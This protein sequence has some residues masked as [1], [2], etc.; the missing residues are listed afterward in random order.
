MLSACQLIRL[1]D[2]LE[3][4]WIY[5]SRINAQSSCL[6]HPGAE[7][8]KNPKI[9]TR[10]GKIVSKL[11]VKFAHHLPIDPQTRSPQPRPVFY[12]Q[13]QILIL[14]LELH[15]SPQIRLIKD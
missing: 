12:W 15:A 13:V 2:R 11:N 8:E 14:N 3:S 1:V 6:S 9:W 4:L 7:I 10:A 5:E